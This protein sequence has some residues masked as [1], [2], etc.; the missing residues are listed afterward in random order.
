MKVFNEGNKYSGTPPYDHPVN[1]A[2]SLLQPPR[3]YG[4]FILA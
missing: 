3:Y 2:T 1:M 4:Y